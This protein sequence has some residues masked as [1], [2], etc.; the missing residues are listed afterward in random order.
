MYE[1]FLKIWQTRDLRNNLIFVLLMLVVFRIF[2]HIPI[3][4]I[5]VSGLRQLF[6]TNQTL[7]L[8]NL[9]SGGGMSNFSIVLMGVGPYI[10]SSIIFQL[11]A[12]VVPSL[13]ELS[14]EGESG[15][16]KINMYTRWAA[17]PLAL[18]LGVYSNHDRLPTLQAL[19]FL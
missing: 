17:I 4:G 13:E 12:M 11:L 1:K 2:A 8:L 18:F 10:T 14:K 15:Q 3:P 6:D 19:P 7:G 16:Q 5:Q 9:F